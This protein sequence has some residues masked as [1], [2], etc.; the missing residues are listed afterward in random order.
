M[1][2]LVMCP[3]MLQ[4]VLLQVYILNIASSSTCL[5][6][7]SIY[8]WLR[9]I[10]F[11]NTTDVRHPSP[12]TE[13]CLN[14]VHTDI[15]ALCRTA[16]FLACIV[17]IYRIRSSLSSFE[18]QPLQKGYWKDNRIQV[19]AGSSLPENNPTEPSLT[20]QIPQKP[21]EVSMYLQVLVM[22]LKPSHF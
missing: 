3:Q 21:T 13:N 20:N 11:I 15:K 1:G 19:V 14:A 5:E 22:I 10:S 6:S 16:R 4:Y 7:H 2:G 9:I 12:F 8:P 17:C 18:S